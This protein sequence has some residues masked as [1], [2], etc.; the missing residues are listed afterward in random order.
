VGLSGPPAVY[1]ASGASWAFRCGAGGIGAATVRRSPISC[2][3]HFI[4]RVLPLA[5]ATACATS[6]LEEFDRRIVTYAGHPEAEAVA[7]LGVPNPTYGG[8]GHR[9]RQNKFARPPSIQPPF[10]HWTRI[11]R[12]GRAWHCHRHGLRTRRVWRFR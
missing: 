2:A 7:G 10:P 11:Q 4:I 9:L 6:I 12:K 3:C 8:N 5:L 1:C